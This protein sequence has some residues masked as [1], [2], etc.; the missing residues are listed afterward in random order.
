MIITQSDRTDSMKPVLAFF[1]TQY[2]YLIPYRAHRL[3]Y[4]ADLYAYHEHGERLTTAEWNPY[5]YGM[6]ADAVENALDEMAA[7]G[8]ETTMTYA[9][10]KAVT[11]YCTPDTEYDRTDTTTALLQDVHEMTRNVPSDALGEWSKETKL[12]QLTPYG[13]AASFSHLDQYADWTPHPIDD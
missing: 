2:R 6:Y 13:D 11:A 12:Y 9:N 4:A 5:M 3:C 1:L 10:G 8:G 7:N